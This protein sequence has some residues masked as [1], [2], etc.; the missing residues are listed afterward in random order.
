VDDLVARVIG[1]ASESYNDAKPFLQGDL[2]WQIGTTRCL[3]FFQ[4][5]DIPFHPTPTVSTQKV[6]KKGAGTAEDPGLVLSDTEDEAQEEDCPIDEIDPHEQAPEYTLPTMEERSNYL[7]NQIESIRR[8]RK[9]NY[10]ER[11]KVAETGETIPD[12][13]FALE[14]EQVPPHEVVTA[15]LDSEVVNDETNYQVVLRRFQGRKMLEQ[16]T[17]WLPSK[18]PLIKERS[19]LLRAYRRIT[20]F[21]G[22]SAGEKLNDTWKMEILA[23]SVGVFTANDIS[24]QTALSKAFYV[25]IKYEPDLER[26]Q[27][28]DDALMTVLQSPGEAYYALQTSKSDFDLSEIYIAL[29]LAVNRVSGHRKLIAA[30]LS[31]LV[32]IMS[33]AL[34]EK[35]IKPTQAKNA[36]RAFL[37]PTADVDPMEEEEEY[38]AT[39]QTQNTK[40]IKRPPTRPDIRKK[41]SLEKRAYLLYRGFQD[42]IFLDDFD[43]AAFDAVSIPNVERIIEIVHKM[44]HG[45]KFKV[46]THASSFSLDKMLRRIHNHLA[47]KYNYTKTLEDFQ[48]WAKQSSQKLK[49]GAVTDSDT[50]AH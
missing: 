2:P 14:Y 13:I 30:Q 37:R 8:K 6:P 4:T 23:H 34:Q 44:G 50:D 10:T 24:D 1:I 20:E 27:G 36:A 28:N 49:I 32:E 29:G 11:M 31:M 47:E 38:P 45:D 43:I 25:L 46:E 48:L 9:Q 17:R 21:T 35:K 18:D 7:E 15:F 12:S 26:I 5:L 16:V 42:V 33:R 41:W 22:Q 3:E 39:Q 19:G 40:K